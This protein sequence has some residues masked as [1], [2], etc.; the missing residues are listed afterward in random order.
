MSA[1]LLSS[2]LACATLLLAPLQSEAQLPRDP[3]ERARVISQIMETQSRQL[4]LFDRQGQ[5]IGV[6]GPRDLYNQPVFS[7]DAKRMA[8]V[9]PDLDKETND[10]WVIDVASA[11]GIQITSSQP[12]EGANSPAWSPDG[13]QVAYVALRQ[14]YFGLYRKASNGQG[15]EELLYKNSAPMTL[16]DWSQDGRHLTYFSTDLSGG[17]LYALPL[18]RTGR[19]EADRGLSQQV[20][21]AGS[22]SL[23]G[24]PVHDLCVQRD[25]PF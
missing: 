18:E 17:G 12:R 10:L 15:T 24:Q 19:A 5:T 23:A 25:R 9:K 1:K 14:G 3:V 7:P 21:S 4:T 11:K 6:V 20:A 16:T 2:I 13:N 8:V 22:A